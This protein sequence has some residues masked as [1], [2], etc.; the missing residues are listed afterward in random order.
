MSKFGSKNVLFGYFWARI[1][2]SIVI[3]E[4]STLEF[5]KNESLTQKVNFGIGS[6]FAKGL[7]PGL[8]PFYNVCPHI[9]ANTFKYKSEGYFLQSRR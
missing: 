8:G 5:V 4:I 6:A 3:F 7:G 1:S 9:I 2:K